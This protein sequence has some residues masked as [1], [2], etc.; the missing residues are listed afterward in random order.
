MHNMQPKNT[1]ITVQDIE[2]FC[3]NY[4]LYIIK[5]INSSM[6]LPWTSEAHIPSLNRFYNIVSNVS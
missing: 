6:V 4:K 3:N 1:Q 5:I 2:M